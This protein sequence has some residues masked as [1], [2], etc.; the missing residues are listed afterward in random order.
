M[1]ACKVVGKVLAGGQVFGGGLL[2]AA[3]ECMWGSGQGEGA[4]MRSM[5]LGHYFHGPHKCHSLF[6]F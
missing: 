1:M 2:L 6:F 5:L 3:V 4:G